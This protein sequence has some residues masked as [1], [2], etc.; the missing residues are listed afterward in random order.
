[1]EVIRLEREEIFILGYFVKNIIY[2][3]IVQVINAD[4]TLGSMMAFMTLSGYFMDPVGRL[5]SL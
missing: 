5:V 1:M 2:F 4:I 3:A